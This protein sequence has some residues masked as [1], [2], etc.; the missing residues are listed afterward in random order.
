M[1]VEVALDIEAEGWTGIDDVADLVGRAVDNAQRR[2][3]LLEDAEAEVSVLL[4]DDATIRQL[5]RNWRGL[6]RPTNVL[7]FPAP[8]GGPVPGPR[9]LGDI[10][11]A[12]E[13]TQREATAEGKSVPDH[14]AHLVVHGFLHVLGFDHDVEAEALRMEA[15][16]TRVLADLGID[17]PY[18][19][20][21]TEGAEP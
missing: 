21:E 8:A 13:T 4:C 6:D 16:E 11:I 19:A 1:T 17:D 14:L 10:A 7:S 20:A 9:L 15:L 12:F 5:N 18:A 3:G 2:S